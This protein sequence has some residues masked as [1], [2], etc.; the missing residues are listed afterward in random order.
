[1]LFLDSVC[2]VAPLPNSTFVSTSDDAMEFS[3]IF[4]VED[5]PSLSNSSTDD[6]ATGLTYAPGVQWLASQTI[7]VTEY[8]QTTY[9]FTNQT[10][11][12]RPVHYF[13]FS[14]ATLAIKC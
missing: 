9:T 10:V 2:S 8:M 1:M 3:I 14:H 6:I 11:R 13:A 12:L 5:H 7:T 4:R